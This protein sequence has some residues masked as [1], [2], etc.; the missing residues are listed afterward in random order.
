MYVGVGIKSMVLIQNIDVDN[1]TALVS[2]R[3]TVEM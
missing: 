1:H 2:D 3:P